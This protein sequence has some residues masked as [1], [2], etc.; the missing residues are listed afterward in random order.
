MNRA[1]HAILIFFMPSTLAI[2]GAGRVGRALGRLLR[3]RG[4]R[5]GA[6]VTRSLRTARAAQRF[7]GAGKPSVGISSELLAADVILIAT[8]DSRIAGVSAEIARVLTSPNRARRSVAKRPLK[9]KVVLHCSGALDRKALAALE[10]LGAATGSMHPFQTFGRGVSPRLDGVRFTLEG[11]PQ[12]LRVARRIARAAGGVPIVIRAADK[13]AYHCAGGFS[14]QH[15]LALMEAA[16]QILLRAGF[17]R[18]QAT[19][20]LLRMARQTLDNIERAGPSGA[21]TGPLSRG[22]YETVARHVKALRRFPREIREAYSA[23]TRLG[24]ALVAQQPRAMQRR[25]KEILNA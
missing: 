7:I 14:A 8:P 4:W 12:A 13:P 5:I 24:V 25:L 21:W 15:T 22:D 1:N 16:V 6:V 20:G 17:S 2:I 18:S 3:E 10:S 23:L 19:A 9:G 11:T